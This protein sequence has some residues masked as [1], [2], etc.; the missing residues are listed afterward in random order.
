[1]LLIAVLILINVWFK[2][3]AIEYIETAIVPDTAPSTKLSTD[4][5]ALSTTI[6]K[7]THIEYLKI[8]LNKALSKPKYL[9]LILSFL[10]QY[11]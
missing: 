1:M 2:V 11:I 5:L 8:F 4:Q 6:P 7:N 10:L 9:I 3:E